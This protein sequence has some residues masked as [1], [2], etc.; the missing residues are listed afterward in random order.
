MNL[1][2]N[3]GKDLE[4]AQ[5]ELSTKTIPGTFVAFSAMAY[6]LYQAGGNRHEVGTIFFTKYAV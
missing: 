4:R 2:V 1:N 5:V 6:E 3:F